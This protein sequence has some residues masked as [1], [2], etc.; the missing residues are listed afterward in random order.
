MGLR[1]APLMAAVASLPWAV[2]KLSVSG[3]PPALAGDQI[4]SV[5]GPGRRSL[6]TRR[7]AKTATAGMS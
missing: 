4:I 2:S 1:C 6:C 3:V 5:M 7:S